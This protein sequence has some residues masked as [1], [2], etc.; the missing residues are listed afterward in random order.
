MAPFLS[1]IPTNTQD[2]GTQLKRLTA[3]QELGGLNNEYN[4]VIAN[5]AWWLAHLPDVVE[6]VFGDA[7]VHQ[8]FIAAFRDRGVSE[9]THPFVTIDRSD[10]H[11]PIKHPKAS[12]T[13]AP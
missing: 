7:G 10:W 9:G 4:E 12:K 8:A 6:A 2:F 3:Y 11:N 1:N 13:A 5:S